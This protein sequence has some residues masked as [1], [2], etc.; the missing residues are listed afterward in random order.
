MSEISLHKLS[1]EKF[2]IGRTATSRE[3]ELLKENS[4]SPDQIF[5]NLEGLKEEVQES[6]PGLIVGERP[7][8]AVERPADKVIE[9]KRRNINT[10]K[11]KE[12]PKANAPL[13]VVGK[14]AKMDLDKELDNIVSKT[15]VSEEPEEVDQ[16]V[17]LL[18]MLE[19]I[20]GPSERQINAWKQEHGPEGVHVT[21]FSAKEIYVYKHLTAAAWRKVK[22][23]IEL[24]QSKKDTTSEDDI[25]DTVVRHCVLWP[26][27]SIEW[28]HGS[29]AG[30]VSA[31]Y[32]SIMLNSYFLSPQQVMA[33]TTEL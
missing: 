4:L 18:K 24:M 1:G 2:S 27:L 13:K 31:L 19:K 26:I 32:D 29:R 11:E 28:K 3:Q 12:Q 25:K 6:Y 5:E 14:E 9:S 17:Q 7:T 20:N 21:V 15:T 8:K 33:I 30:I 16:R 22:E 10:K 23:T